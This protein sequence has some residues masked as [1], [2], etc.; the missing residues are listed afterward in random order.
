MCDNTPE[1]MS[2]IDIGVIASRIKAF[3]KTSSG[4]QLNWGGRVAMEMMRMKVPI[5]A[6]GKEGQSEILK[7][8]ETALLTN[9]DAPE[10]IAESIELLAN[11]EKLKEKLIENSFEFS[12]SQNELLLYQRKQLHPSPS[13]RCSS[14]V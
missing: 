9:E 13:T 11:D 12:M 14:L 2:A 3:G 1:I 4:L 6:T 7:D 5:V 8:K 10:E